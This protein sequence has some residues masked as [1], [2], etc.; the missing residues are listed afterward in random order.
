MIDNGYKISQVLDI[1]DL[2]KEL[3]SEVYDWAGNIRTI[4]IVKSEEVLNGLSVSY[5]DCK[6]VKRNLERINNRLLKIDFNNNFVRDVARL[7]ANIWQL[8]PFREGNTRTVVVFLYF[9]V[10]KYK[11]EF[12]ID[13]LEKHSKYFRN[14]LVLASIGEYSEYDHLERILRDTLFDIAS[15]RGKV[16][17]SNERYDTIK[18]LD[19]KKY[20]Y[21]Y[22]TEK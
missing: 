6:T 21:N 13:F 2:H 4:N 9:L 12:N 5:G 11:I 10:K 22:H 3:F 17:K 18:S 8:H 1:L 19:L 15:K 14:A 20:K 7:I 16:K